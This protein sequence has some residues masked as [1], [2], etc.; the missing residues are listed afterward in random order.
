MLTKSQRE[1]LSKIG[2]LDF[3]DIEEIVRYAGDDLHPFI[4]YLIY[5]RTQ[6]DRKN[7]GEIETYNPNILPQDVELAVKVFVRGGK[8]YRYNFEKGTAKIGRDFYFK[9][10]DFHAVGANEYIMDGI[11]ISEFDKNGRTEIELTPIIDTYAPMIKVLKNEIS[12]KHPRLKKEGQN[13]QILCIRAHKGDI[14]D[15]KIAVIEN[16]RLVAL[17]LPT[18]KR[19]LNGQLDFLPF[20]RKISAPNLETVD[21]YSFSDVP[22]LAEYHFPKLQKVGYYFFRAT[23]QIYTPYPRKP[24]PLKKIK[25]ER[26]YKELKKLG[27]ADIPNIVDIVKYAGWEVEPLTR[28]LRPLIAQNYNRKINGKHF[29]YASKKEALQDVFNLLNEAGYN[30]FH[31]TTEEEKNKIKKYFRKGEELCTFDDPMRHLTHFII[32]CVKKNVAEIQPSPTPIRDDAYGTSVISIQI[33]DGFISIKNRYNDNVAAGDSTFD[34]DP[35]RIIPGLSGALKAATGY[36]FKS[37]AAYPEGFL[38]FQG[39][40]LRYHSEKNGIFVGENFYLKNKEIHEIQPS[41]QYLMGVYLWD[42][43]T[44]KVQCLTDAKQSDEFIRVLERE[45]IGKQINIKIKSERDES[46]KI[47][48]VKRELYA[49]DTLIAVT[50]RGRLTELYL[51]TTT[52]IHDNFLTK[53]PSLQII[54]APHVRVF[55]N[56]GLSD[57][58]H[59]VT[60]DFPALETV[61]FGFLRYPKSLRLFEAENLLLLEENS[62]E[63]PQCMERVRLPKLKKAKSHVLSIVPQLISIVAGEVEEWGDVCL[64]KADNL[65]SAIL[66]KTKKMGAECLRDA[67]KLICLHAPETEEL[68]IHC[69]QKTS[70]PRLDMPYLKRVGNVLLSATPS[71]QSFETGDF[72]RYRNQSYQDT[73][74]YL[75][76]DFANERRYALR[77]ADN[78]VIGLTEQARQDTFMDV[79]QQELSEKNIKIQR[80]RGQASDW[81]APTETVTVYADEKPILNLCNH[82]VVS[83]CLPTTTNLP[84]HFLSEAGSL[85]AFSAPEV[86][87]AGNQIISKAPELIRAHLPKV[88]FAGSEFLSYMPKTTDLRLDSLQACQ[89]GSLFYF[90]KATVLTFPKLVHVGDYFLHYAPHL[91]QLVAPCLREAP[92]S[93]SQIVQTVIAENREKA[94]NQISAIPQLIATSDRIGIVNALREERC[95]V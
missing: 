54:R 48:S 91:N 89:G 70:L 12:G 36:D 8:L 69:L 47:L 16:G 73:S 6:E 32:H 52:E 4:G 71:I 15:T 33:R 79:L 38:V 22:K 2:M 46:G 51:P 40:I 58:P 9:D 85:K 5:L 77:L 14:K 44:K 19:L 3:P 67:P 90:E 35:E 31:A 28:L 76:F 11:L 94:R 43:E 81:E 13:R 10:G 39:K 20:C 84:N 34:N 88:E 92:A 56:N 17:H 64:Q 63:T 72:A 18:T 7:R 37:D 65:I 57:V 24:H 80:Q 75:L 29:S 41:H 93:V 61:G 1:V 45:L 23:P 60:A 66:P 62:L 21:D 68:G 27:V 30:A 95:R 78:Q 50:D 74:A 82:R 49:D 25:G 55:G 42:T 53:A 83:L 87:T 26:F 86:I 59:L